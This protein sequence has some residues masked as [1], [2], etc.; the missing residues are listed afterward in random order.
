MPVHRFS[1]ILHNGSVPTGLVLHRCDN[2]KCVNPDH[3]FLGDDAANAA[4][5]VSKG[6]QARGEMSK[7]SDLSEEDVRF[8]RSRY[9]PWH[10][11][12]GQAAL[13]RRFGVSTQTIYD[14]IRLRYWRHVG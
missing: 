3:L 5:K 14:I 7:Q 1:F 12:F 13:A 6:R 10:R 9:K 4:D 2:P 11:E 8:I